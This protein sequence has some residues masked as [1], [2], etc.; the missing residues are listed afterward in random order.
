VVGLEQDVSLP[1]VAVDGS[2]PQRY[3]LVDDVQ[4]EF[5]DPPP[6]QTDTA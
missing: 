2:Q 1:V 5:G 3:R 6:S 4:T